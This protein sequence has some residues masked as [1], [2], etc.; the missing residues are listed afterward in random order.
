[1]YKALTSFTTSNYDVKLGQILPSDFD[2]PKKIQDF[3]NANY[4]REYEAGGEG[5]Q[6]YTVS[7]IWTGTQEQYSSIATPDDNTL[8]F[9]EEE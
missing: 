3:L 9:I 6:S 4:I 1:M 5:I 7:D 2:T 8:Y